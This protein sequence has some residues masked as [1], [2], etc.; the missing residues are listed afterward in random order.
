MIQPGVRIRWIRRRLPEFLVPRKDVR[1]FFGQAARGIS[2]VTIDAAK[3]DVLCF[4][5]RLHSLMTL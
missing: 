5:H 1:L 2:A 4:V 3:H